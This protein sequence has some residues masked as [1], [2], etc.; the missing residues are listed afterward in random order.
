MLE[1]RF[2]TEAT[3]KRWIIDSSIRHTRCAC[4]RPQTARTC[5]YPDSRTR[6]MERE[7]ER[8][9]IRV[10]TQAECSRN[11]SAVYSHFHR[12]PAFCLHRSALM[13]AKDSIEPGCSL[14]SQRPLSP[15]IALLYLLYEDRDD[16]RNLQ[17]RLKF[18]FPFRFSIVNE[19]LTRETSCQR[20]TFRFHEGKTIF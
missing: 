17:K 14:I 15:S 16:A 11:G 13:H 10:C 1:T 19:N 5:A 8:R 18:N 3:G 12:I 20:C 2:G 4:A 9:R 7:N 6:T